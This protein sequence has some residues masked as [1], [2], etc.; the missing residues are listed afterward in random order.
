MT[1]EL[2]TVLLDGVPM[3]QV[4]RDRRQRLRFV[5]EPSWRAREGAVPLSLSMPLAASEH[6]HAVIE[7]F[8]WGLL[9]E[10]QKVLERWGRRFQV[11]PRNPFALLSHVG[12]DCAGAAQFVV[13]ERLARL[14]KRRD[15]DVTWLTEGAVAERLRLL[16]A[17]HS[18]GR[19]A[20]DTGQ[21]SL[22]GAQ[23]KTALFFE[24]GRWGV[25]SGRAPTTHILK[26][27]I[28]GLEGHVENEHLCLALA[29]ELG[30]PAAN[31][32]V[33]TFEDEI[34]IVVERYDRLRLPA[35]GGKRASLVRIHQ[36]DLCQAL[37]LPPTRKYQNEG[38]PAPEAIATLLRTHSNRP[39]EDVTTFVDALIFNWLVAGTDAHAKNY[40]VLLAAGGQAR[41]APLYDLASALPYPSIDQ[42]RL[43]LAMKIGGTYALSRIGAPHLESLAGSLALDPTETTSRAREIAT[44]VLE[45]ADG[46]FAR[47]KERGLDARVVDRLRRS[48]DAHAKR[49]L[50]A[51]GGVGGAQAP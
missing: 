45:T 44:G 2:L 39:V 8:L 32:R 21:F 33:M 50:K 41:L 42:R 25:P 19:L 11:S 29:R 9:P 46:V 48:I 15:G 7:A 4:R 30:L 40:S 37:G 51:L 13:P 38:G 43:K 14:T 36:E 23:A 31:S 6:D 22:A 20:G 1:A 47:E 16:R 49:C 3:G 35:G 17:D 5:Y 18:S 34:A 26:P 12:E 27:P 10:N 28:P 24:K